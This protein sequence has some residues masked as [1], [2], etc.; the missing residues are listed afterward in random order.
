MAL[1]KRPFEED[2]KITT[3]VVGKAWLAYPAIVVK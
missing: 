1:Q 2:E 3:L